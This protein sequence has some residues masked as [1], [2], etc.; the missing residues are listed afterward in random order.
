MEKFLLYCSSCWISYPTSSSSSSLPWMLLSLTYLARYNYSLARIK[1]GIDRHVEI[2]D[3]K[4][5]QK[6]AGKPKQH[7]HQFQY[8]QFQTK[9]MTNS[10][11]F[12]L[13]HRLLYYHAASNHTICIPMLK[14]SIHIMFGRC[15]YKKCYLYDS[16]YLY[17]YSVGTQHFQH[18][19]YTLHNLY[20]YMFYSGA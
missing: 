8:T 14:C 7:Q 3:E 11:K 20:M 6:P 16:T 2:T 17:T 13:P 18:Y 4:A 9:V 19:Y 1:C 15:M 10:R 12:E 5:A